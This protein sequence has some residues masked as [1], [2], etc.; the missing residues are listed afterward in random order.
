MRVLYR[1]NAPGGGDTATEIAEIEVKLQE[2]GRWSICLFDLCDRYC[3]GGN[4]SD[5]LAW[6]AN[7]METIE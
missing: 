3:G 7:N 6:I 4:A 5:P 2:D 1:H